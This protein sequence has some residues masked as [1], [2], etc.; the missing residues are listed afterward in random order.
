MLLHTSV[1]LIVRVYGSVSAFVSAIHM[2]RL[3]E[4]FARHQ[5]VGACVYV[6]VCVC[7]CMCRHKI[8]SL[9]ISLL[10]CIRLRTR[11]RVSKKNFTVHSAGRWC[12]E[13]I[14]ESPECPAPADVGTEGTSKLRE[15]PNRGNI[16]TEGAP[17]RK[18]GLD[19]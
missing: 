18:S 4:C 1:L 9:S 6:C 10:F 11:V 7:V 19:P 12:E 8:F 2:H 13:H 17:L 16:Q 14:D 3:H 5:S 15:H